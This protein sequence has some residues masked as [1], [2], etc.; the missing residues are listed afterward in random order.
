MVRFLLVR[1]YSTF[2]QARAEAF[3]QLAAQHS[4]QFPAP[5]KPKESSTH[6]LLDQ[7]SRTTGVSNDT[8]WHSAAH[9]LGWA[10]ELQFKD[11]ILL[12]DGPATQT[13]FFYDALLFQ[14]SDYFQK[15]K[16]EIQ[17]DRESL[18]RRD[19]VEQ[20]IQRAMTGEFGDIRFVTEKE[21]KE[22]ERLCNRLAKRAEKVSYLQ[23]S[24]Q[25][26]LNL[27][28]YSPFKLHTI[29]SL[30]EEESITVYK[31]GDFV[32]LCR[33]PHVEHAKA[34]KSFWIHKTNGVQ[35]IP[36][37]PASLS[38]VN[39]TCFPSPSALKEYQVHLEELEKRN[40]RTIGLQQKLFQFHPWA[41]GA[42]FLLPHGV[43]IFQGLKKLIRSGYKRMGFEEVMTPLMFDKSLW[44][45]SGHWSEYRENMFSVHGCDH[46]EDQVQKGLKPMNCPA[47]CLIYKTQSRSFRDLPLRFAEFSALH[48]YG[49]LIR[50]EASGAL[51]GLTRVVQFHQDDGHIFCTMEQIQ[52]E[53]STQLEYM[54][55]I[56]TLFD[57]DFEV[58]LST[59]PETYLGTLEEW[60][61]AENALKTALEQFCEK[62]GSFH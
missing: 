29:I 57:M 25:D 26:A 39:G 3:Q 16:E 10:L 36:S 19:R 50:N 38:R 30:P 24:R 18:W 56:Y 23:I 14:N 15:R 62:H 37:L 35:H 46:Q 13:G 44:E 53:I 9:I 55:E 33:G 43:R 52:Q 32:D 22:I 61:Q 54:R 12:T 6:S 20:D 34:L 21:L 27:F 59:R 8:Y 40:H 17:A 5:P 4:L 45:T 49:K 48:R 7:L 58:A 28:A 31:I 51:S 1:S 47:H 2:L 60:T 11:Q 41:P 42:P